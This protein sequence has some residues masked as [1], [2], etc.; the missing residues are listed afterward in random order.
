MGLFNDVINKSTVYESLFF[1]IKAVLTYPTL[2]QLK[3][4][5]EELYTRW[6]FLANTKY[7]DINVSEEYSQI[8]YEDKAILYPEFTRIVAIT[9]ATL[10]VK[11]GKLERYFKRI[12]NDNEAIVISTFMD[13]LHELSRDGMQSTP[14]HFPILCGHNIIANDIPLLM[15]RFLINRDKL[16]TNKTLPYILKRALDIKPWES[17]VLDTINVF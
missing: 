11:D 9:Y 6:M 5:N 10:Y 4:E 8:K 15:K 12:A 16:E 14:Y 1:N 13:V 2:E 17:G 3:T 7:G